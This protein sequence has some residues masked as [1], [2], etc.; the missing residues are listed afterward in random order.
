M[1]DFSETVGHPGPMEGRNPVIALREALAD[2]NADTLPGEVGDAV[3]ILIY[4]AL[5][6]CGEHDAHAWLKKNREE[7]DPVPGKCEACD[8]PARYCGDT[9]PYTP[10]KG[11]PL[12]AL[13]KLMEATSPANWP[14][15]RGYGYGDSY[16]EK[17]RGTQLYV[18]RK[19]I[20]RLRG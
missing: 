3:E 10:P 6:W 13:L 9:H 8:R 11:D 7:M 16:G 2:V 15:R 17:L 14:A 1:T 5:A 18:V 4:R 12:T 19:F 20:E